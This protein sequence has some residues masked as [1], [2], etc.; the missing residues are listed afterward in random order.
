M[1]WPGTAHVWMGNTTWHAHG[2]IAPKKATTKARTHVDFLHLLPGENR[3]W[4]HDSDPASGA[5]INRF[6]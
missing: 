3:A 5:R 1:S 2:L 4:R 6:R